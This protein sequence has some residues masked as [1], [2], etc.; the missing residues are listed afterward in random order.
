MPGSVDVITFKLNKAAENVNGKL[1]ER[2]ADA[3]FST[4]YPVAGYTFPAL[5]A[6]HYGQLGIRQLIGVEFVAFNTAA[7]AA[8]VVPVWNSQTGYLVIPGMAPTTDI[9]TCTVTLR[10]T[11]TR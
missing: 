2:Y 7:I 8:T 6:T 5:L 11:G 3:T 1:L 4:G 10:L 9:S